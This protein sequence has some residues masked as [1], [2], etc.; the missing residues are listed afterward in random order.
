MLAALTGLGLSAAAGLNAYIPLLLVGLLARFT[1]VIVLPEP[2]RWIQSGWALGVVAVLLAAELVLDKVAVVDHV[3]DAVQTLVRP[4]VGGVIFAATSA[5]EQADASPWM[6]QHQWVAVLLGVVV[7]GA[8]HPTKAT[9]RPLVNATTVG[10]ATP[11][12]SA[13]EDA[14]SLGLSLVAVFLPV[15]VVLVVLLLAWAA[16]VL[17]RRARRRR[18]RAA[19]AW[20]PPG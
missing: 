8:V 4:T 10:T 9:A 19:T 12:V 18:R 2:Y 3:N 17:V 14:T 7:A 1:E 15:L 16:L 13:A 6:Q 5:A 20:R 11:A